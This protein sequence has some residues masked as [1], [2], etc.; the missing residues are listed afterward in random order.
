MIALMIGGSG[1]Y[2]SLPVAIRLGNLTTGRYEFSLLPAFFL[3]TGARAVLPATAP[4]CAQCEQCEQCEQCVQCTL[5][6]EHD[7]H[8]KVEQL[9][10]C[11]ASFAPATSTFALYLQ[12]SAAQYYSLAALRIACNV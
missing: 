11:S 7:A 12:T 1:S 10:M 5:H 6:N 4:I 9:T 2:D 3:L 8:V